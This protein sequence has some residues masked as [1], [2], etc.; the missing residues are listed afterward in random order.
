M[1][2]IYFAEARYEFIR[3]IRVPG[4]AIPFLVLPVVLY[5]F[6]AVLLFGPIR[7]HNVALS[8]FTGFTVFG[9]MGPGL[10]GAGVFLAADRENGLL[11]L[12]KAL[13]APTTAYLLAKALV[14]MMLVVAIL[15]SLLVAGPLLGHFSLTAGQA[16][17]FGLVNVF[18]ALPFCALGLFIG[19]WAGSKS[20]PAY[21]HLLYLPMVYLSGLLFPMPK[22]MQSISFTSPAYYLDQLALSALGVSSRLP[23]A[24]NVLVLAAVTLLFTTLAVRRLKLA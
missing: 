15:V 4:F 23:T 2:D 1:N 10:F 17:S 18:G 12:K 19:S 24:I 21:I 16:L 5:L 13:P 8:M 22:S 7:D 14:C 20:A 11:T 9:V 6:F 3:A